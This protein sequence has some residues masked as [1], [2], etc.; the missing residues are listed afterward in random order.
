[1]SRATA[2]RRRR[3]AQSETVFLFGPGELP[4][5]TKDQE[6]DAPFELRLRAIW[7]FLAKQVLTF[8]DRCSDRDLANW[9]VDDMLQEAAAELQ[10]KDPKWDPARGR[11]ITFA[12]TVLTHMLSSVREKQPTVHRPRN[13][14]SKVRDLS[15]CEATAER[16]RTL[17]TLT[18]RVCGAEALERDADA[19]A[20]FDHDGRE[21]AVATRRAATAVLRRLTPRQSLELA[22]S[23]G[24]A[25]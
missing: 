19:L 16:D 20:A 12:G 4:R 14:A 17:A 18:R 2:P 22:R 6:A 21:A 10:T 9:S 8:A 25:R 1:M 23:A 15:L 11:Y 5:L 7:Q 13:A 3:L 24:G